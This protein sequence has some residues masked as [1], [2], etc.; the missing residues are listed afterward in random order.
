MGAF[1]GSSATIVPFYTRNTE[2]PRLGWLH[3]EPVCIPSQAAFSHV[4]SPEPR[5]S[6]DSASRQ[7]K[8]KVTQTLSNTPQNALLSWLTAASGTPVFSDYNQLIF[9]SQPSSQPLPP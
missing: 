2:E 3:V 8:E 4:P 6:V 7:P 1:S 9:H 5:L